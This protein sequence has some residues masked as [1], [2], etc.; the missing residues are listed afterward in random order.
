[1]WVYFFGVD[2]FRLSASVT[3]VSGSSKHFYFNIVSGVVPKVEFSSEGNSKLAGEIIKGWNRIGGGLLGYPP[4]A[5]VHQN[6][7]NGV[8][9]G[10]LTQ[11]SSYSETYILG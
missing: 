2:D 6:R 11:T 10:E 5:Y 9:L 4:I 8:L 1:M 7:D 3:D